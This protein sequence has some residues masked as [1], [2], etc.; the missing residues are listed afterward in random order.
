M[1]PF[2]CLWKYN[3]RTGYYDL[4]RICYKDTAKEWLALYSKDEPS[5]HFKLSKNKPSGNPTK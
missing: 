4:Q 2:T 5:E 1:K 3:K